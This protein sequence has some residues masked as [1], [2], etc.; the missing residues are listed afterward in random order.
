MP[1]PCP[2]IAAAPPW[3]DGHFKFAIV[4]AAGTTTYWSND[5]S[6]SDGGEPDASVRLTVTA[7]LFNMLLGDTELDNMTELTTA[8]FDETERYLRVWFSTDD[9]TYLLLDPDRRIAAVPYVLQ[10]QEAASAA[11]PVGS[12]VRAINADGTVVCQYADA[13]NRAVTPL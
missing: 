11:C 3:C 4:D 9:S 12:T 5:G 10:A 7:G 13:L 2:A 1:H 8:V 6:S